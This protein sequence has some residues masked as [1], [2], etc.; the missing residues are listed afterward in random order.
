MLPATGKQAIGILWAQ[1]GIMGWDL[2]YVMLEREREIYIFLWLQVHIT[3]PRHHLT[4]SLRGYAQGYD[5]T[6]CYLQYVFEYGL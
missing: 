6:R 5:K 2:A 1:P 3:G 4:S